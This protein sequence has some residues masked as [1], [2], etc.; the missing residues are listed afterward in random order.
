MKRMK[1]L[2]IRMK[3]GGQIETF[4]D[5]IEEERLES[6]SSKKRASSIKMEPLGRIAWKSETQLKLHV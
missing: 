1:A 6:S 2:K 5:L 3:N 4:A